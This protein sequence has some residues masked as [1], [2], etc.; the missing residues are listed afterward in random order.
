MCWQEVWLVTLVALKISRFVLRQIINGGRKKAEESGLQSSRHP[1][2]W[3]PQTA[4][5]V[6]V[7]QGQ[8]SQ[9]HLMPRL[10][11][12]PAFLHV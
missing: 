11:R 4:S 6:L 1:H 8:V 10:S 12:E 3:P 7:T 5:Q 9:R 2:G